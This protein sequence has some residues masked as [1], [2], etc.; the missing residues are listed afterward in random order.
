MWVSA[1]ITSFSNSLIQL[2]GMYSMYSANTQY[3]FSN[4]AVCLILYVVAYSTSYL[5]S[6]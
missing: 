2:T 1:I 4:V 5:I 6:K 3:N